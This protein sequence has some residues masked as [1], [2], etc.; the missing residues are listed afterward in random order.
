VEC[1]HRVD[2]LEKT[3]ADGKAAQVHQ[4][5]LHPRLWITHVEAG[6]NRLASSRRDA[7][8]RGLLCGLQD[9][10]FSANSAHAAKDYA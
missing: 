9:C 3:D 4:R 2:A 1:A 10:K 6:H 5:R 8:H 7:V